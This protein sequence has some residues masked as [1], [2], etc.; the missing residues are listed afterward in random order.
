MSPGSGTSDVQRL[1]ADADFLAGSRP[2]VVAEL[3]PQAVSE[4]ARLAAQV[5]RS[6]GLGPGVT[7]VAVRRQALRLAALRW[8]DRRLS[9]AFVGPG[10]QDLGVDW[11][12]GSDVDHRL[13]AVIPAGA[14]KGVAAGDVGGRLMV[15]TVAGSGAA[16]W[17]AVRGSALWRRPDVTGSAIATVEAEDR[18]AVLVGGGSDVRLLDSTTGMSVGPGL[19]VADGT[20][21]RVS[22]GGGSR[23]VAVTLE[24]GSRVIRWDV[25]SGRSL[26]PLPLETPAVSIAVGVQGERWFVATGHRE[27]VLVWDLLSGSRIGRPIDHF[28][29]AY[30]LHTSA[31]DGRTAL[32]VVNETSRVLLCDPLT[33][34]P[35]A[36]PFTLLRRT[37]PRAVTGVWRAADAPPGLAAVDGTVLVP[38]PWQVHVWNP[39]GGAN[40]APLAGL[41]ARC[42]V[43]ATRWEHRPIVVTSSSSGGVVSVWNIAAQRVGAPVPGHR[44]PIRDVAVTG[45]TVVALDDA[46]TLTRRRIADGVPEGAPVASGFVHPNAVAAGAGAIFVGG[47]EPAWLENVIGRWSI[48]DGLALPPL[49][50]ISRRQ[51]MLE[52]V[53]VDGRSLLVAAG[54]SGQIRV[55]DPASGDVVL[56]DGQ[57]A[58]ES[59]TGAAIG[60]ID[61]HVLVAVSVTPGRAY[62]W[63]ISTGERLD[64]VDIDGEA[65]IGGAFVNGERA[66]LAGSPCAASEPYGLP[67]YTMTK[68]RGLRDGRPLGVALAE[69]ATTVT[70][71]TVAVR[72]GRPVAALGVADGSVRLVDLSRG[73]RIGTPFLLPFPTTAMTFTDSG[74]LLVGYG[75]DLS[76]LRPPVA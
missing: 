1:L 71:V 54:G 42:V 20:I 15:M 24:R 75:G 51:T 6:S 34:A 61:G 9:E 40:A 19:A 48:A 43:G 72:R 28:G 67:A 37:V 36:E 12:T 65:V 63:D 21:T 4:H 66:L 8:G 35:L 10:G 46:A 22:T 16:A 57:P 2:E 31:V 38:G 60:T 3:L 73:E 69:P 59:I 44:H 56:S 53:V 13:L 11:A 33:G 17:D 39:D 32:V 7:D 29:S 49:P 26:G 5:Y 25:W 58:M 47:G 27:G 62:T 23:P 30:G 41:T 70:A 50:G 52:S 14:A 18:P 55:V 45:E 64:A 74:A 68:L 76:L